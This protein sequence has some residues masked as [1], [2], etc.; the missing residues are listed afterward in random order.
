LIVGV[1]DADRDPINP[2]GDKILNDSLLVDQS[3]S[4]HVHGYRYAKLLASGLGSVLRYRPKGGYAVCDEGEAGARRRFSRFTTRRRQ[5][6]DKSEDS[7]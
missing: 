7:H 6:A 1:D 2:A 4:W 5:S 3:L